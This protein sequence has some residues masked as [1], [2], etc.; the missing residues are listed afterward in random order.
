M[1]SA[2]K[3]NGASLWISIRRQIGG[4]TWSKETFKRWMVVKPFF[5]G[6]GC[7]I[8]KCGFHVQRVGRKSRILGRWNDESSMMSALGIESSPDHSIFLREVRR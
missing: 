6:W 1:A 7:A 3:S 4:K 5:I 2:T 8:Q